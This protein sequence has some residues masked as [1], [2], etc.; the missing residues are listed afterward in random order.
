MPGPLLNHRALHLTN[1]AYL[2]Q[3]IVLLRQIWSVRLGAGQTMAKPVYSDD[4]FRL[5]IFFYRRLAKPPPRAGKD[6]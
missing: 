1:R 5:G 4:T 2:G 6:G 3:E